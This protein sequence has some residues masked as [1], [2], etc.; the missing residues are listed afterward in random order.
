MKRSPIRK[1][2]SKPRRGEP[3]P[4]EKKQ[5]RDRVYEETGGMCELRL[6]PGCLRGP[7]PKEGHER[8]RWHLVHLHS[9]R[10]FGWGRTNL[11][12]GCAVC[13]IDGMHTKGLRAPEIH[14]H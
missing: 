2:R 5:I 11:C 1:K 12:G 3:S 13:H 14:H 9:K 10:R 6:M 4:A 8:A 7:L